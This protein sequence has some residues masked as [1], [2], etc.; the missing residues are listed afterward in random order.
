MPLAKHHDTVCFPLPS[1]L[2]RGL[3]SDSPAE[4]SLP[5]GDPYSSHIGAAD[6]G[7]QR[8]GN[9]VPAQCGVNG[10]ENFPQADPQGRERKGPGEKGS[11]P[12]QGADEEK[13]GTKSKQ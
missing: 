7:T 9:V 11:G 8:C 6:L 12:V 10:M 4:P 1:D 13:A 5:D 2:R 3:P